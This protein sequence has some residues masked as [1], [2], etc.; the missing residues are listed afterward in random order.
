MTLLKKLSNSCIEIALS[1][2]W[3]RCIPL[4]KRLPS[5]STTRTSKISSKSKLFDMESCDSPQPRV[6]RIPPFSCLEGLQISDYCY[7]ADSWRSERPFKALT[8]VRRPQALWLCRTM[9]YSSDEIQRDKQTFLLVLILA[10]SLLK[11]DLRMQQ[12]ILKIC[13]QILN[14]DGMRKE[15]CNSRTAPFPKLRQSPT[16]ASSAIRRKSSRTS[17]TCRSGRTSSEQLCKTLIG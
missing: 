15:Y 14:Q 13:K 6:K 2:H 3:W 4:S 16:A 10:A 12:S 5:G 8:Y 17:G 9:S 7:Q 1:K 11:P